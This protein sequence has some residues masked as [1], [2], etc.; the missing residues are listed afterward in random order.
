MKLINKFVFYIAVL[1]PLIFGGLLILNF[2]WPTLL[3]AVLSVSA[4]FLCYELGKMASE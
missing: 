3:G 2:D 1:L 4:G